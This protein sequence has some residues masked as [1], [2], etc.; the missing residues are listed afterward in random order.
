[1]PLA[2]AEDEDSAAESAHRLFRFGPMG[3]KV[4]AELPNPVNF[5]AATAFTTPSDLREAFGCGPDP[6]AHL[7]VAERFAE[8][9]FDR[10][11]L[12]N[13]GPDPE[14]FFTF[15]ENELAEPVRELA[16]GR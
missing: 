16:R 12:I 15:F 10:L 9:G 11:A 4:Q 8:A 2:W 1:M 7:D 3:W 5:E 6:R 13:A 14:G